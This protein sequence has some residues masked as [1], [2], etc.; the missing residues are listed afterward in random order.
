[1]ETIFDRSIKQIGFMKRVPHTMDEEHCRIHKKLLKSLQAKLEA[2]TSEI[3]PLVKP[4]EEDMRRLKFVWVWDII[5]EAVEELEKWQRVFDPAW[6]LILRISDA[7]INAE[8]P[9]RAHC[10]RRRLL[11]GR[12][13]RRRRGCASC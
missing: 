5:D 2:T 8:L 6:Y 3:D 7:H 10:P 4:G 12:P 9:A 13:S 1:M 11:L